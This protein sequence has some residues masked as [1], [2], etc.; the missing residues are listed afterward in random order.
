MERQ[1]IITRTHVRIASAVLTLIGLAY[2]YYAFQLPIGDP[3][4]TGEGAF[5]SA[6]GVLW[7]AFGLYITLR[8][9]DIQ[10]RD[11]EVGVWP[12]AK[13]MKRLGF[14]VALCVAFLVTLPILGMIVTSGLFLILMGRLAGAAWAKT[15]LASVVLPIFF[16]I[17]FVKLLQVSL[18]SGV[19]LAY[20]FGS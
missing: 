13:M 8:A 6:V 14:A 2:T 9:P 16:W 5:P 7:T 19:L 15:V 4:G 20:L 10:I 17:I 3:P 12:D 11:G 1:P 18:P